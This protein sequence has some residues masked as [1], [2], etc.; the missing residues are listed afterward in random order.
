MD[1]AGADRIPKLRCAVVGATELHPGVTE[2]QKLAGMLDELRIFG[3]IHGL[4]FAPAEE[5]PKIPN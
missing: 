1:C 3:S 4:R 2:R 5:S